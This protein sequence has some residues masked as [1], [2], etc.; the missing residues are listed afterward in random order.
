ME[1]GALIE[2]GS[3]R[4]RSGERWA[5]EEGELAGRGSVGRRGRERT[6]E[7]EGA[8]ARGG[9]KERWLE[10]RALAGGDSA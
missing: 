5:K 10:G 8:L 9:R 7:E 3:V 1:K 2:G 6:V 4:W